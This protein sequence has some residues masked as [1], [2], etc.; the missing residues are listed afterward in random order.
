M[1][2]NDIILDVEEEF[3]EERRKNKSSYMD[4]KR[5]NS[6]WDANILTSYI[7]KRV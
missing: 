3:S 2:S 6:I 5:E 1:D 4:Q 7:F